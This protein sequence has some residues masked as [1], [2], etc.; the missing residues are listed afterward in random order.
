MK[1]KLV[2]A[3]FAFAAMLTMMATNPTFGSSN[4]E[5][6]SKSVCENSDGD[7]VD[8]NACHGSSGAAGAAQYKCKAVNPGGQVVDPKPRGGPGSQE[9]DTD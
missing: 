7:E 8:D 2:I 9:C 4:G 1:S 5:W 3:S 6:S